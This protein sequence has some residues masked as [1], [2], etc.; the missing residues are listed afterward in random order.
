MAFQFKS[1]LR[2]GTAMIKR[3]TRTDISQPARDSTLM[4]MMTIFEDMC[5]GF[6]PANAT[7]D[8]D[9]CGRLARK[10]QRVPYSGK[11]LRENFFEN[12]EDKL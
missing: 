1:V 2:K 6:V 4:W 7:S 5:G 3:S 8:M 12:F 10:C 9:K 11:F